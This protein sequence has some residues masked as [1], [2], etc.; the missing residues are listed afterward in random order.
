M[1]ISSFGE[2]EAGEVYV[3]DHRGGLYRLAP[4]PAAPGRSQDIRAGHE[5]VR[6]FRN[7]EP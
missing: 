4:S 6:G 5:S 1:R 3:V 7:F 2:D